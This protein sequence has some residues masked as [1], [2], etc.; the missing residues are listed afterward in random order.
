MLNPEILVIK[1]TFCNL[2]IGQEQRKIHCYAFSKSVEKTGCWWEIR[3]IRH[4]S[5]FTRQHGSPHLRQGKWLIHYSRVTLKIQQLSKQSF[6]RCHPPGAAQTPN[7]ASALVSSCWTPC[8]QGPLPSFLGEADSQSHPH[9][10]FPTASLSG[11]NSSDSLTGVAGQ[12]AVVCP[13]RCH[14]RSINALMPACPSEGI[15]GSRL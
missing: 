15:N 8:S 1:V 11:D 6:Q 10:H 4:S 3:G 2:L 14:A 7:K 13:S 9:C 5:C 12:T